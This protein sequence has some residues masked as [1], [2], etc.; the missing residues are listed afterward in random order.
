ME[1]DTTNNM[2]K[3][4]TAYAGSLHNHP[5]EP[6][7]RDM[8]RYAAKFKTLRESRHVSAV[9]FR[10]GQK[11]MGRTGQTDKCTRD[12][13][14]IISSCTPIYQLPIPRAKKT[15]IPSIP[16]DV[17]ILNVQ[18]KRRAHAVSLPQRHLASICQR[19]TS[20]PH[21]YFSPVSA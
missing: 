2:T 17:H 11:P 12:V 6:L 1:R 4:I 14:I 9:S 20:H 5:M 3:R 10:G 8:E 15:G 21:R 13:E 7:S 19:T 18:R 16:G